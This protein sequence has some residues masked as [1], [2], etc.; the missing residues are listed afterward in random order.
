MLFQELEELHVYLKNA[1]PVVFNSPFIAVNTVNSY[2]LLL[3]VEGANSTGD[4]D[5]DRDKDTETDKKHAD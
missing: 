2:S 3:E 4:K 1:F 5:I